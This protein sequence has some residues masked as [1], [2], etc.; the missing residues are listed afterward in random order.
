MKDCKLI[1]TLPSM[2]NKQKAERLFECPYIHE[3]RYNTGSV[4]PYGIKGT[5]EILRYFSKKYRKKL[6]IDLK[7]RQLRIT[8]WGNPM[9]SC[10][11]INHKIE[12]DGP[13]R[14]YLRN[15]E[16][17]NIMQVVDGDNLF[18]DPLPK[19]AV[20]AGQSVNI[21]SDSLKIDGYLTN[22]DICYINEC[23]KLGINSF[24][25]SFVEDFS[26]VTEVLQAFGGNADLVL[27][28]ESERGMEFVK[29]ASIGP[30]YMAARDDLYIQTGLGMMGH[31]K[32]I[33]G[34]DKTAICAS[35]IFLSLEKSEEPEF[36]DYEDLEYMYGLGYREFML[37]DNV[38]NY[39][40][41]PAVNAWKKWSGIQDANT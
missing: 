30:R 1:A 24:M 9:F 16:W 19:H 21:L 36:C 25:L 33:I 5:L 27:K 34:K 17:C 32:E 15:G 2:N 6:W 22:K 7:G 35:R 26:D 18:V 23:A 10:I 31:L 39:T 14:I 38:C 13:A 8:E 40:L 28:I 4:S 12:L 20:G 11:K 3:V 41:E 29:N 37:C